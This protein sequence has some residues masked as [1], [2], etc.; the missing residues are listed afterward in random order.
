MGDRRIV[1]LTAETSFASGDVLAVDNANNTETKKIT[2]ANAI[3]T[4]INNVS[5][6]VSGSSDA[7][8]SSKAYSVGDLVI[9]NNIVYKCT[10]ACSAASWSV[11]QNNFTATTLAETVTALNNDLKANTFDA[12]IGPISN[13][14]SEYT[15]PSD[16]YYRALL[17]TATTNN[18]Y[19]TT[20][21]NGTVVSRVFGHPGGVVTDCV[22]VRKGMKCKIIT[23]NANVVEVYFYPIHQT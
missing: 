10:T 8:S 17:T 20:A 7:Y 4:P 21:I 2:A 11:N 3:T 5:Q 13:P 6:K 22:F 15:A 14:T 18:D 23:S 16:G 9:Y 12:I 1:D 19:V